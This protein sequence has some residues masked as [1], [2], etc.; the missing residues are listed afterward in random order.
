MDKIFYFNVYQSVTNGH[1]MFF[2]T[3][4]FFHILRYHFLKVTEGILRPEAAI[5]GCDRRSQH[6]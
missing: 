2:N 5:V 6:H 1:C 3:L 4:V